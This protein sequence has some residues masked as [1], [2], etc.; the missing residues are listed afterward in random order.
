[1]I[2]VF[3]NILFDPEILFSGDGMYSL[4]VRNLITVVQYKTSLIV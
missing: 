3:Y 4:L 2:L 1:V